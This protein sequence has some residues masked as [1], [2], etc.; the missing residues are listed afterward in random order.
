MLALSLGWFVSTPAL[1]DEDDRFWGS[2]EAGSHGVGLRV[3]DIEILDDA[4]TPPEAF[5]HGYRLFVWYPTAADT[6]GDRVTLA[7]AYALIEE[8]PPARDELRT[9]FREDSG[10]AEGDEVDVDEWLDAELYARLDAPASAGKF[11]LLLW[12]ARQNVPVG[13]AVL[14]EYLASHGNVV[15][16]AWPLG[17]TPPMPWEGHPRE[18]M[19]ETLDAYVEMLSTTL[20]HLLELPNVDD[21]RVAVMAWSYGGESATRLAEFRFEVD[22]ILSLSATTLDTFFGNTPPTADDLRA[23]MVYVTQLA[24]EVD[25][26]RNSHWNPLLAQMEPPCF[27]IRFEAIHH[28]DFNFMTGPI[29]ARVGG[30]AHARWSAG[31]ETAILGY[32]SASRCALAGIDFLVN[33]REEMDESWAND[34]PTGFVK[35]E[36]L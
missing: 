32:E 4:P 14:C 10:L 11:P 24:G 36:E 5:R 27:G 16:W 12:S 33:G 7:D 31:G 19:S 23:R 22:G 28:G 3:S 6:D 2:L 1:E 20:D 17:P 13:Q 29:A 8:A 18:R 34:L 21:E 30:Q 15:A 26:P 35:I 9:W 25:G